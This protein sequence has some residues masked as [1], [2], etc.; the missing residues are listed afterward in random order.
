MRKHPTI[1][2]VTYLAILMSGMLIGINCALATPVTISWTCNW[3]DIRG[4]NTVH[5]L[6]GDTLIFGARVSPT[7]G[8]TVEACQGGVCYDLP[9]IAHPV[10]P[11]EFS[12]AIRYDPVLTGKWEITA[13]N[14]LHRDVAETNA[15]GDVG[16]LPF[17]RN[18]RIS[19]TGLT[20]TIK[21]DLPVNSTEPFTHLQVGIFDDVINKKIYDSSLL[22]ASTRSFIVPEGLL[23]ETGRYVF[24][25]MLVNV[26]GKTNNRSTTFINFR[27]LPGGGPDEVYFPV[28]DNGVFKFDFDVEKNVPVFIDPEVVIGYEYVMG[29]DDTVKFA[30][31]TLPEVG[32]NLFDLYLFDG[33]AFYLAKD[34]LASGDKYIFNPEGVDRFRILGI[35]KSARLDP[36]DVAAFITEL[37]F[38]DTGQ[39]TGTMTPINILVDVPPSEIIGTWDDGTYYLYRDG[40]S[41]RR[42]RLGNK[43]DA[44]SPSG[45][46][47]AD[48]VT[49]DSIADVA[50]CWG[51]GLYYQNGSTL[52]YRH[53]FS[54][55]PHRVTAGDITGDGRA[56]IIGTFSTG[57][58]YRNEAASTWTRMTSWKTTGDIAAGDITGDGRADVASCWPGYG[59]YYQ[60]GSTLGWRRITTY[61][62]YNVAVGDMTGDGKAEV[63]GAFPSGI[64]YWNPATGGWKRLTGSGYVTDGDIACGDF[65]G[66]GYADLVSCWNSGLWIVD[67]RTGAWSQAYPTAPYRV[68]AGD[69]IGD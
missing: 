18:T 65:N 64:W 8:T 24:R 3:R 26:N 22:T 30:S 54:E 48:D 62:P 37:T 9:L 68:T 28:V 7:E 45:D 29:V 56:E 51:G 2:M 27:P 67:G 32:D 50:S 36:N 5:Y 59:L 69:I 43:P 41:W 49:G 46:I 12:R 14:G 4:S 20:P 34:N 61:I 53:L 42:T 38:T 1:K 31:I 57:V 23:N 33:S 11:N 6:T 40:S 52:V 44:E 60:N 17:V 25:V 47:E 19:G 15:V 13:T 35:E 58:W 63:I 39:F 66:D 21:W 16:P 10:D 55:S